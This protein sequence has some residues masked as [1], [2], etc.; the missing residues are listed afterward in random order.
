[1]FDGIEVLAL[2]RTLS[3]HS[4]ARQAVVAENVANADTP[5]YR[6]RDLPDF[7]EA[8]RTAGAGADLHRT[9]AGHLEPD[10]TA[11]SGMEPV[12]QPGQASPNGNTVS[13]ETELVRAAD[14]RSR[15]NLALTVY[16]SSLDIIRASI[17][18]G[19]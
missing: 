15:H 12:I 10:H 7:A 17:G 1:M 13:L 19:R 9:R 6:A 4:G 11:R 18:R 5:G 3:V 16:S 14:I 2:A 8:W